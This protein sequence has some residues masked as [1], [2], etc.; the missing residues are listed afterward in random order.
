MKIYFQVLVIAAGF[1][2][3]QTSFAQDP[4]KQSPDKYKVIFNNDR[5]RVLDV[6]LKPGDKSPMHSHPNYL[7]YA[8]SNSTVKFTFPN[9]KTSEFKTRTG[10]C[11]WRDA[12][13]HAVEN[14]GKTEAHVLN[15]ELK[16]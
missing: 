6:H 12:E 14:T 7:V 16:H 4:V 8:L 3:A 1:C 13:K 10:Q 5:V 15:I 2:F 11:V 9:G